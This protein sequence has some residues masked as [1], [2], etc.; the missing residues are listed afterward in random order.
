MCD[1]ALKICKID[2]D[3]KFVKDKVIYIWIHSDLK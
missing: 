3:K 1:F 2:F